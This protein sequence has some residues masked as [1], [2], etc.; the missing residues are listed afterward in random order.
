MNNGV[1]PVGVGDIIR[2]ITLKIIDGIHRSKVIKVC[3]NHFGNGSSLGAEGIVHAMDIVI[4][5]KVQEAAKLKS[6]I[7]ESEEKASE[8]MN[9]NANLT[10]EN[11]TMK[12]KMNNMSR[13][14]RRTKLL[15]EKKLEEKLLD[16]D[17][18]PE[19]NSGFEITALANLV[20]EDE[21]SGSPDKELE[22][23]TEQRQS[24][25]THFLSNVQ[26]KIEPN[27]AT[28]NARL[29]RVKNKIFERRLS[30]D[31]ASPSRGRSNSQKRPAGDLAED[32]RVQIKSRNDSNIPKPTVP[33]NGSSS[34]VSK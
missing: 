29:E 17:W 33:L 13:Q 1:R 23:A 21:I 3:R 4:Q 27:D 7:V 14:L 32:N 34:I 15:M 25:K 5:E 19:N 10:K 20:N 6:K 28:K 31:T 12:Q 11:S 26:K 16:P 9:K 8:L 30:I 2:R 22:E 24:R 18:D